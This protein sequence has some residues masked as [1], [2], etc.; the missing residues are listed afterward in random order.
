MKCQFCGFEGAKT[1]KYCSECGAPMPKQCPGCGTQNSFNAN[2]CSGCGQKFSKTELLNVETAT[3]AASRRTQVELSEELLN[4]SAEG[5]RRHATVLRSDLSGYSAMFEELDPEQVEEIVQAIMDIATGAIAGRGGLITEFRGDELIALFGV[6]VGENAARD[7]VQAALDL[8]D[9][10]SQFSRPT[11]TK[12][13][14]TLTMHTGI[15]TG[16][17][18]VRPG[19]DRKGLLSISGDPVN[20]AARL[21]SVAAA[22]EVLISPDTRR[23]V[24]S[25]F[26]LEQLEAIAVKGKSSLLTPCRVIGAYS[27]RSPFEGWM[28]R[29]GGCFAGRTS[30]LAQLGHRIAQ[31]CGG[32]GQVVAISAEAGVGKSRLVYEFLRGVPPNDAT[33]LVGRCAKASVNAA[34]YPWIEIVHQLLNI[35]AGEGAEERLAKVLKNSRELELDTERHVPAL[36]HL[37]TVS[38]PKYALSAKVDGLARGQLL[39]HALFTL[40]RRSASRRP[41]IIALEDWQWADRASDSFIRHHLAQLSSIPILVIITFRASSEI[42]WPVLGHLATVSLEPLRRDAIAAMIGSMFDLAVVPEWLTLLLEERT[43]GNPLF[44]EETLRS[45]KEDRVISA[46]DGELPTVQHMPALSI[47]DTVQNVVLRRLDRLNPDWREILRR[48]A[49]IGREFSQMILE[50]LVDSEVDLNATLAE[51]EELGFV[52]LLRDKP[53]SVFSFK[54]VIIQNVAYETLLLKQRRDLHGRV[55]RSIEQQSGGRPEEYCESLAYHYA[56][57]DNIDR[58]VHYLEQAGERAARSFALHSARDQFAEALHLI[59][60]CE[61]TETLQRRRIEISLKLASVSHF[62]T[63]EEHVDVMR[64]ALTTALAL[65][66]SRLIANCRYWLGRMYYGRGDPDNAIVEF[67]AALASAAHL[68]NDQLLGRTYCVLGRL[69]L[70]TTESTRGIGYIDKGIAILRKCADHGEVAYSLSSHACIRAFIGEFAKAEQLFGEALLLARENKDRTNE[71]LVL[72][73]LSYARCLRGNWA[74][75]IEAGS[76][77]LQLAND[78]G[79]PVLAAFCEIFR[80]YSHWMSGER[81]RGYQDMVQA[82]HRYQSTRYQLAASICHGWFAEIAALQGDLT[83]ARAHADLSIGREKFGDRFGQIPAYRALARIAQQLGQPSQARGLLA[84]A[85]ELS[86]ARGA[87]PDLG[88]THFHAAELLSDPDVTARHCGIAGRIFAS[89]EMPWWE[90]RV[91]DAADTNAFRVIDNVRE[92]PLR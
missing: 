70:F 50:E 86:E 66:D 67:E 29:G 32:H 41:L 8:H 83:R 43:G 57:D 4:L 88:I 76:N 21:V 72:Q 46:E 65:G 3:G 19:S 34:Y 78:S 62:A 13:G 5:E 79:L 68:D 1:A 2:F 33:I 14:K 91:G 84:K 89:T 73:Q 71:A 74:G 22:N 23:W 28:L 69:S 20:M 15:C 48:A 63:S 82:I 24:E 64:R 30:E 58:A 55:A 87:A 45:L 75:A 77:C 31:A 35:E 40:L 10:V 81:E 54:H 90:A 12:L 25:Y 51:L 26:K 27:E 7:A 59:S 56:R 36:C 39:W 18:V 85:I 44:I 80:A 9:R 17:V 60:Q 38:H 37:L 92:S 49:V 42:S 16:L 53:H 47:P 11:L 61:Q 6:A 52:R